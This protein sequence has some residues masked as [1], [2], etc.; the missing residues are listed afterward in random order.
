[1]SVATP[2]TNSPATPGPG[3]KNRPGTPGLNE[4]S[5]P[6]PGSPPTNSPRNPSPLPAP[7]PAPQPVAGANAPGPVPEVKKKNYKEQT[8]TKYLEENAKEDDELQTL[9]KQASEIFSKKGA[10]CDSEGFYQHTGECWND[11]IQQIFCNADGI[12]EQMQYTYIYWVFNT[13][14]YKQLPDYMFVPTWQ[15]TPG[16]IEQFI[17]A[18]RVYIDEIK[19]WFLLYIRECQKRFLRHYLLENKRRNIKKEI[20]ELHG[21]EMG[22][23]AREKIMAISRD[24]AFRK[25]GIQ[26]QRSAIFG[27]FS[28][29]E[30]ARFEKNKAKFLMKPTRE[31]Y[32]KEVDELAG[33]TAKDEDYII[34]IFNL[35]FFRGTL[36]INDMSAP[37]L[38]AQILDIPAFAAELNRTSGVLIE[39]YHY[40]PEKWGSGH[41]MAFYE[42]GKQELFYEDNYGIMIFEWRK[43]ILKYLELTKQNLEP[44]M[45]FTTL[46]LVS[47]EQKLFFYTAFCPVLSYLDKDKKYHT[48]LM[49]AGETME[50]NDGTQTKFTFKKELYG[51]EI[52]V[53][54]DMN[55]IYRLRRFVLLQPVAGSFVSNTGFEPNEYAR[56]ERSPIIRGI[57]EKDL[58]GTLE[59]IEVEKVI[60][61]LKDRREG[62]E[63]IPIIHLATYHL[64]QVVPK[65]IE[66]G[67]NY[68]LLFMNDTV[69]ENA[70]F[71]AKDPN[72]LKALFEKD[73]S[74]LE[75][76]NTYG[77]TPLS[78]SAQDDRLFNVTKFLIEA[79]AEIESK[80]DLGRTPLFFASRDGATETVKYLCSK[81]ADP[82]VR[83]NGNPSE[84][85]QPPRTP[86]EV[87]ETPEIKEF[88]EKECGKKGGRRGRL[89]KTRRAKK[90]S[91]KKTRKL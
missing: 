72:I 16:M 78:L 26:A 76:R 46:H 42:C 82:N 14:Y 87:A 15:R 37:D 90:R 45:E 55:N 39:I 13:D 47:K 52:K 11:A 85:N 81:G 20:C 77:R 35:L 23:L 51:V 33:G 68:K 30:L 8:A 64:P 54:Y 75:V 4:P 57:L 49:L 60:P 21:P 31:T 61:D 17:T 41:A 43:Y 34:E 22:H 5:A 66:K 70:I 69:L 40:S 56:I 74:L 86:I 80:S 67:Y 3:K 18:N 53:D 58:E 12:K 10:I 73:P 65:L 19:K 38:R 50:M 91:S 25:G 9:Q 32:V 1:M 71:I 44:Q 24:P 36:T 83:D 29:V 48:L 84:K 79:G 28:N 7:S 63:D 89:R 6:G 59:A 88:L 2:P 62:K 27:K